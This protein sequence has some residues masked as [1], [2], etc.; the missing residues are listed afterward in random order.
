MSGAEAGT[1]RAGTDCSDLVFVFGALRSGTTVF[2]LML[3]A[4]PEIRNPGEMDFLFDHL[5]EDPAAPGGWRYDLDALRLDRIFRASRLEIRPSLTGLEQLGDFLDQLRDRHGQPPVLSINIHRNAD[6]LLRILPEVRLIHMLRDPRDVAR[7][8]IQ[9]GWAGTL[10]HGVAHWMKT[11]AAWDRIATQV[12][13]DHLLTLSYERLFEATEDSLSEVCRFLGLDYTSAMLTY[14]ENTTY[15]PP[16]P[17]LVRQWQ[18]KSAPEDIALLEHRAGDLMKRRGYEPSSA[19]PAPGLPRLGRLA[20][21]NKMSVWKFGV[22]RFGATTYF[23][24]KL[25]RWLKWNSRNRAIRLRMDEMTT[26]HL[27]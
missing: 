24:E 12:P 22:T 25:T 19:A 1:G 23:G 11:E 15:G 13:A 8:S 3:D 7:S 16:D 20:V 17:S 6:R 14:H 10:Y 9:M 26:R 18:R 21:S 27:K 2:R 5:V 4:H